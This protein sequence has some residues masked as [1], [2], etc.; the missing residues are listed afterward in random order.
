MDAAGAALRRVQAPWP[1][2]ARRLAS[3]A[4]PLAAAPL[5]PPSTRDR[6]VDLHALRLPAGD[7]DFATPRLHRRL[8][9]PSS[10]CR[11]RSR[12]SLG[13]LRSCRLRLDQPF[14]ERALLHGRRQRGHQDLRHR[15]IGR[16]VRVDVRLE[17]GWD[18]A[19]GCL[20]RIRPRRR[21]LARRP[22][23]SMSLKCRL[24]SAWPRRD[25][26]LDS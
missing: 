13:R 12:R 16:T 11:F 22:R 15:L 14:G 6:R 17:F 19:P 20:A 9:L 3:A 18:R 4:A 26:L 21:R 5:S 25:Q 24:R 7:Q 1:A 8:R 2:S 23:S 10:P